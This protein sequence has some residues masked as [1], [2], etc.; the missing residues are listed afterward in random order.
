MNVAMFM[1]RVAIMALAACVLHGEGLILRSPAQEEKPEPVATFEASGANQQLHSCLDGKRIVFIGP[2]TSKLDYLALTFFAEYG[3]WPD[4]DTVFYEQPGKWSGTG[5]NPLFAPTL[6]YGMEIKGQKKPAPVKGCKI[7]STE[8]YLRYSNSILNGHE[9]CDCYKTGEWDGPR[10][11]NNQTENRIYNN[12][13]TSIAYFQWF[14]DVVA[15]R[16]TFS[17]GPL[18]QQPPQ[19]VVQQCPAGQFKGSWDWTM[20]VAQFITSSVAHFWPTHL[21][22]DAAFW[23]IEPYNSPFWEGI[24]KAGV[25][26]VLSSHGQV[27]WRTTPKRQDYSNVEHSG[28]VDMTNLVSKGWNVFDAQ[29]IVRQYQ[30]TRSDDAVFMDAIHLNPKT[31]CHLIKDFVKRLV[32]PAR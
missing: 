25:S 19:P 12:G 4:Q 26:A 30:G 10:D 8:E 22:V 24:A 13:K 17:F 16:G 31:Q 27:L 15:P 6:E 9:I 28:S 18:Q 29:N 5:P 21:I 14:G 2:S 3:R 32:C 1:V 20:P 23:P 11:V 7:G